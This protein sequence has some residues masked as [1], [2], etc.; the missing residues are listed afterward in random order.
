MVPI[1]VLAYA[2]F[3]LFE[4]VKR[5]LAVRGAVLVPFISM[6]LIIPTSLVLLHHFIIERQMYIYGAPLAILLASGSALLFVCIYCVVK[7]ENRSYLQP[8][9]INSF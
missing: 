9:T 8:V 3:G 5:W 4:L 2:A 7:A 1:F 6:A